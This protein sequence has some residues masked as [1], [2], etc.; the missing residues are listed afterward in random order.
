ME[1]S[2]VSAVLPWAGE[3][4]AMKNGS[5]SATTVAGS[6]GLP[7]VISTGGVKGLRPTK[8]MKNG[9]CSATTVARSSGLPFVISTGGVM[10]LRPTQ[11][12][13]SGS[14]SATTVAGSAALPFVISTGAQRSG[15]ICGVSGPSLGMFFDRSETQRR[16]LRF[17]RSLFENVFRQSIC[18]VGP[19]V[20]PGT[21]TH[22]MHVH[23]NQFALQRNSAL[24][25]HGE[26][27]LKWL[28]LS[29]GQGGLLH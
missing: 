8:A 28:Y 9:S 13:Q 7:F 1:R 29:G 10:G 24:Q 17:H 25:R 14:C 4:K 6:A 26:Q 19:A 12:D 23:G 22:L 21:R 2:A 27:C 20:S 5:C 15:E 3:V 11:G 16:D 18:R